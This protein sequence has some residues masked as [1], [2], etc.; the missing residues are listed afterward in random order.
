MPRS[1]TA[2]TPATSARKHSAADAIG[3]LVAPGYDSQG[4]LERGLDFAA[5]EG[6]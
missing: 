1:N 2:S 6:D 3:N 5:G 4:D